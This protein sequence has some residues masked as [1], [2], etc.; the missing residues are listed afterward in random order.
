MF[1][2]LEVVNQTGKWTIWK[3]KIDLC[4]LIRS[5]FDSPNPSFGQKTQGH[6]ASNNHRHRCPF[7]HQRAPA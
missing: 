5:P 1:T 6:D 4:R 2:P 7:Y 3:F